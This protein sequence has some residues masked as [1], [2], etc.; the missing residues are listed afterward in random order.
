MNVSEILGQARDAISVQRVFGDPIE[1]NGVMVIPVARLM[2]GAGGGGDEHGSDTA[3][4]PSDE[5]S[6]RRAAAA[7]SSGIGFGVMAGP[8]GV[9]VVKGDQVSWQ[10]AVSIE[11]LTLIGGSLGIVALLIFRS[12]LRIVIRH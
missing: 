3:D 2:G 5:A 1:K 6:A 10:P 9:Y 11:R 8:A 12:M 4:G 7:G